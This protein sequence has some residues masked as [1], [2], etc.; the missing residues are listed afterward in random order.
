MSGS[1]PSETASVRT[2][3]LKVEPA[4]RRAWAARLNWFPVRP[5]VTAVIVLIAPL[6]GSMA[7]IADAGSSS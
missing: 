7:T 1:I 6:R 5:G 4:W 2:Y 3:V